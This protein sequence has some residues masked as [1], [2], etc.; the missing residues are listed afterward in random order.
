MKT[1]HAFHTS[2]MA[3]ASEQFKNVLSEITYQQGE[4]PIL[5]NV[6]GNWLTHEQAS[7]LITGHLISDSLFYLVKD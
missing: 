6:T 4:I 2:M 3:E 7:S 5:S 1:S